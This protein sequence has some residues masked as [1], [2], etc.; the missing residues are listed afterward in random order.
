MQLIFNLY[1][2][3][4]DRAFL[5]IDNCIVL[6]TILVFRLASV[7]A[8]H[9]WYVNGEYLHNL[10]VAH[11]WAFGYGYSTR[12]WSEGIYSAVHPLS[13]TFLYNLLAWMGLDQ[14]GYLVKVPHI[15]QALLSSLA[16]IL[17]SLF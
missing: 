2:K 13:I 16:G 11:K 6:M 8:I 3:M 5:A 10:E 14:V 4:C 17:S 9:P 7:F 1:K 15:F 12:G